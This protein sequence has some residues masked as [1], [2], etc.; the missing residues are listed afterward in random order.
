MIG[1]TLGIIGSPAFLP[2]EQRQDVAERL[3][4]SY[5]PGRP[6][7]PKL[8]RHRFGRRSH[9]VQ[10]GAM[11][12]LLLGDGHAERLGGVVRL[13]AAQVVGRE[14]ISSCLRARTFGPRAWLAG[15]GLRR[16]SWQTFPW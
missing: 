15:I 11:A 3:A 9:A 10:E 6:L 2:A 1:C 7:L 14:V 4:S 13:L 16:G 5:A 12:L 8:L